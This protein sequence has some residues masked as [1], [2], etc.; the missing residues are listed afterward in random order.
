LIKIQFNYVFLTNNT[1]VY[2]QIDGTTKRVSVRALLR[3]FFGGR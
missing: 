1:T 2:R 3:K